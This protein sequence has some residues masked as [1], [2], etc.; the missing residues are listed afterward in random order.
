MVFL[1][2][3]FLQHACLHAGIEIVLKSQTKILYCSFAVPMLNYNLIHL[4][5]KGTLIIRQI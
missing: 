2:A 3:K 4:L 5:K 1:Q